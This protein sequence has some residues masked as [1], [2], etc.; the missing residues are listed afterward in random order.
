MNK[1][2]LGAFVLGFVLLAGFATAG[3]VNYLSN[4]SEVEMTV[5]WCKSFKKPF[6]CNC[7]I[8]ENNNFLSKLSST[9]SLCGTQI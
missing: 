3:L 6:F 4:T 2:I 8:K 7:K 9:D 5:A 1:K